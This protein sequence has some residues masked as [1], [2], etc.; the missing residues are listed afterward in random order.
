MT[1]LSDL[2]EDF[3]LQARSCAAL[4]SPFMN[5]L[6]QL[7]ADR[8][9]PGD[10][11]SDALF[12]WPGDRSASGASVP[13]RLAGGLHMLVLWPTTSGSAIELSME[14]ESAVEEFSVS[15]RYQHFEPSGVSF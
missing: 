15:W 7:M 6:M 8:L 9:T 11:V 1:N 12:N 5:Q 4:G 13:L 10:P 3:R 2:K 14:S